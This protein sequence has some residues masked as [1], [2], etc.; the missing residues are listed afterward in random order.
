MLL[1]LEQLWALCLVRGEQRLCSLT[2]QAVPWFLLFL[3]WSRNKVNNRFLQFV[4][5]WSWKTFVCFLSLGKGQVKTIF[6]FSPLHSLSLGLMLE[7]L[8]FCVC[9]WDT[10]RCFLTP[11]R[12]FHTK[13]ITAKFQ[14]AKTPPLVFL[15]SPVS[16]LQKKNAFPMPQAQRN[17]S[18]LP[19]SLSVKRPFVCCTWGLLLVS[20]S[21]CLV[22]QGQTRRFLSSHF[23]PLCGVFVTEAG[24]KLPTGLQSLQVTCIRGVSIKERLGVAGEANEASSERSLSTSS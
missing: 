19:G 18:T 20:I 9:S 8:S 6:H 2:L 24:T 14:R 3:D 10:R 16:P 21:L 15:C 13:V 7:S 22:S 5:D 1:F 17:K 23:L 12:P 11:F 4:A